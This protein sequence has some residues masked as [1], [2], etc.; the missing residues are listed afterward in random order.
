MNIIK[1]LLIIFGVGIL[2]YG[3]ITKTDGIGRFAIILFGSLFSL[4]ACFLPT[5][6]KK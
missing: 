3:I 2:N 5:N 6:R 1:I 4:I